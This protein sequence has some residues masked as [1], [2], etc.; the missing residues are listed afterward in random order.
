MQPHEDRVIIEK[1]ELD[2]RIKRLKDFCFGN[3]TKA[4]SGLLQVDQALLERQY[5]AMCRYSDILAQRIDR[6]RPEVV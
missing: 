3:D 6:F 4:F 1:R 5:T 2:E